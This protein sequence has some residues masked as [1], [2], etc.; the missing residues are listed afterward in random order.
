VPAPPP[1]SNTGQRAAAVK[2]CEKKFKGRAKA[3]KRKKCVKEAR[4]L[5]L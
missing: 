2:K 3:R 1:P 4:L 5:P